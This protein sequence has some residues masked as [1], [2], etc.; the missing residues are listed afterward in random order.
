M[1]KIRSVKPAAVDAGTSITAL[2]DTTFKPYIDKARLEQAINSEIISAPAG[3][4]REEKKEYILK[5]SK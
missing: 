2:S 1:K 4:S 5:F 3:M